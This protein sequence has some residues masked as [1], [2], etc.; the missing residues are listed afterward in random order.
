MLALIKG[1]WLWRGPRAA[2]KEAMY[3]RMLRGKF[4]SDLAAAGRDIAR[5]VTLNRPVVSRIRQLTAQ[6]HDLIVA[7]ASLTP[8]VQTILE[9]KGLPVSRIV[10]SRAEAEAGRLT[11]NLVGFE[12]F[13]KV[14]ARRVAHILD[15]FYAKPY[16][17]AFG[18][19]PDDGP[20]LVDADEA[21]IVKGNDIV[22]FAPNRPRP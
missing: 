18:N 16:V 20:M 1:R 6:G 7:S 19:W 12:C 15:T 3:R 4:E 11:G 5:R 8:I 22:Q 17:I 9:E 13:G 10:G 2:I 14:K 21:Y